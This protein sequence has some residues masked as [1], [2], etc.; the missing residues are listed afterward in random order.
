MIP[1]SIHLVVASDIEQGDFFLGNTKCQ[2]D[3]VGMG[4]ACSM[5][6]F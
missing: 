5:K 4:D 2:G 3:A 6:P 1:V